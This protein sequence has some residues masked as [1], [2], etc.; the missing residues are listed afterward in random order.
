MTAAN[1]ASV[2]FRK[3]SASDTTGGQ[4]VEV[5]A[6]LGTIAIR[7]SKCPDA[8]L[9]VLSAAAWTRFLTALSARCARG[10]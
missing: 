3:S 6:Q 1:W 7:D 4:C 8:G 10:E 9:V 5:G 2:W